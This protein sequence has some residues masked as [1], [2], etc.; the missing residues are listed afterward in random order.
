MKTGILTFP[1]SISYGA[2][3][4]MYALYKTVGKMGHDV[5]VLNY[6]NEYMK[7]E[8]HTGKP[9]VNTSLKDGIKNKVRTL[10]HSRLY[11]NFS[12]FEKQ[13]IKLYPEVAFTDKAELEAV[14]KRY[15]AV[16]CGSDQVWNPLITDSDLSYYLSFCTEKT[17]RIS[18]APS[19]GIE[20]FSDEFCADVSREINKFY[21]VSVRECPGKELVERLTD[22]KAQIVIDPTLLLDSS[23]WKT[24]EKRHIAAKGDYIL[25]YA[26][27]RSDSLFKKCLEFSKQTGIKIVFVGGNP[28]QKLKNKNPLLEYAV[29]AS[30]EEWLYLISNARYVFTNSFHGTAFSIINRK[31]FFVE[32]PGF[33]NSRLIQLLG[34]LGL[35]KRAVK[36]YSDIT[37]EKVDYIEVNK[38]LSVLREESLEFLKNAL[39]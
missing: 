2:A 37:D 1:N 5:E 26:A 12:R 18:Y 39:E 31:N 7:A 20:D 9:T 38:K 16:I 30:P 32:Y 22:K 11:S 21:A 23:E 25:Y 3:L 33:A 28:V 29:D 27:I 14:G 8:K 4:Q 17:R 13:Y 35:E 24:L 6:H 19:F 10:M 34:C 36:E 15:E